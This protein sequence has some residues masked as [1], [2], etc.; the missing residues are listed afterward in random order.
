MK[1]IIEIDDTWTLEDFKRQFGNDSVDILE[2]NNLPNSDCPFETIY[3]QQRIDKSKLPASIDY[4]Y[5]DHVDTI[6]NSLSDPDLARA[7]ANLGTDDFVVY[8]MTGV[9]NGS[10]RVPEEKVD[11]RESLSSNEIKKIRS[12]NLIPEIRE[13]LNLS[14]DIQVPHRPPRSFPD[15]TGWFWSPRNEVMFQIEGDVAMEIPAW[16][17]SVKDSTSATWSQE[18]TTFQ[19]YEP[20]QTYKG[21]GPRTVSCTFKLHRAMWDG[22]QD[23]GECE[24]LIAYIESACYPDY[25]TQASNAPLCMLSIG[26]SISITGVLTSV[27]KT[28]QGPIG[29]D[30]KYD[31]VLITISIVEVSKSVLST[32]AVRG[33][34]AGWR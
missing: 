14:V 2:Y 33:G 8:Q 5:Q 15:V 4:N 13:A 27:D 19:H 25:S 12:T 20:T 17:D 34:L 29:P 9:I 30:C 18:M 7:I 11:E 23:S 28:Y 22:N 3:R 10:L 6:K 31:E 24:K 1:S 26:K 16:P 21:S 32:Q